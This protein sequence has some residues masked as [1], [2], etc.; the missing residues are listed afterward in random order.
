MQVTSLETASPI[1]C[2]PAELLA[3]CLQKAAGVESG[4]LTLLQLASTSRAFRAAVQEASFTNL[5]SVCCF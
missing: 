1:G 4:R 3:V 5:H 2:L